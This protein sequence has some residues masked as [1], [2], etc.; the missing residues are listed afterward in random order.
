[1][2]NMCSSFNLSGRSSCN[3]CW[4]GCQRVC[5]DAFGNLRIV[6]RSSGCGC[7]QCDFGSVTI[8][9]TNLSVTENGT[10]NN[11]RSSCS[12]CSC[13][14]GS[15][16]SVTISG[17]NLRVTES[18][19]VNNTRSSCSSCSCNNGSCGCGCGCNN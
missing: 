5:R 3:S 4:N 15:C 11:T 2:C 1:M 14:N 8:S 16:G 19:T 10:V 13:N 6:N 18:G 17:T 9:G 7:N 12:S